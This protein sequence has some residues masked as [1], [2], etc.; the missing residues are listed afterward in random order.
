MFI[1]LCHATIGLV[2][3]DEF[4]EVGKKLDFEDGALIVEAFRVADT[5]GSGKLDMEEFVFAYGPYGFYGKY[6]DNNIRLPYKTVA[7]V[8]EGL[9][10]SKQP[11]T[12]TPELIKSLKSSIDYHNEK[13]NAPDAKKTS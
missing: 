3:K 7:T 4:M 13:K 8:L 11:F 5:S 6:E 2:L 1:I 9:Q 10:A 12:C